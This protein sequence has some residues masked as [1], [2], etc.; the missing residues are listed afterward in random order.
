MMPYKHQLEVVTAIAR[1]REQGWPV[2]LTLVGAQWG[3]YGPQVRAKVEKLDPT[4]S[5]LHIAGHMP[6]DSLHTLYKDA[7]AFIFAS[8]CENLPN[9]L[10][11]AMAAG[12]PILSSD[13]GPMPEVLGDSGLYFNP[14]SVDS[15]CNAVTQL[16]ENKERRASMA[17]ECWEKAKHYSWEK[18]AQDT[19]NFIA[20]VASKK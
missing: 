16:I 17:L 3:N 20:E 19:L 9:I 8:S 1:L 4:A 5:F 18:C 6:F 12:L 15:I 13:M 10:I 2:E 7:D 14:R 11:E